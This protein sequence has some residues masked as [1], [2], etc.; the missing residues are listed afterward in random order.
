[1]PARAKLYPLLV[2]AWSVLVAAGF[3]TLLKFELTPGKAAAAALQWPA[4]DALPRKSGIATLVMASHP[5]CPCT[6]ASLTELAELLAQYPGRM[7]CFLL[8]VPEEAS[9]KGA[10]DC[11]NAPLFNQASAIAG[12]T[13]I[14]DEK[15][16]AIRA[17]H[18]RTSG[19]VMLYDATGNLKFSGGITGGRD[20]AGENSGFD[21][22]R[23]F[24]DTGVASPDS[25]PV[26]GCSLQ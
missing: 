12:V 1:M 2:V 10:R 24:F 8:F 9:A 5:E 21:A 15:L 22:I 11:R 6:R 26:F 7:N 20:H 3:W 18:A 14:V 17:F 13:C 23:A 4:G 25:T 16:L 19:Q